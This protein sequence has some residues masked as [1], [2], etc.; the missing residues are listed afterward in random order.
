MIALGIA[1]LSLAIWLHLVLFHGRF[2]WASE[3]D[4]RRLPPPPAAWPAVVAVVPARDE[5]DVVA[6]SVGSLLAQDYPGAFRV[7]LVDDGSTD[8][9]A[10][11]ARAAAAEAGRADRLEV[12]RAAPLAA[13]WTGKLAAVAQGVARAR[14]GDDP[15][16]LMLTDADIGHAPDALRKLV[17]RAEAKGLA[18]ASIMVKLHCSTPAERFLIPAFVFFFQMLYP[19]PTANDPRRRLAAGA[20]GCMLANAQALERAGGIAAIR[21]ALI[22]DCTLAALLKREGPIW[23]GLTRTSWSLR[24]YETVAQVGRM[25]SRSAYAQLK[26]SPALLVGTVLGMLLVYVVPPL[27]AVLGHGWT[28]AMGAAAWLLMALS[29]Q[30]TLR[31]YRRSPLWGL[32]LPVIGAA[33][34]VFTVQ[35][36]LDHGRGRGGMWKGRAQAQARSQAA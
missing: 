21:G 35:S 4:D 1:G 16:Y 30:P 5:A 19:F 36:A 32:V 15:K 27:F 17:V 12:L 14:Q 13:G 28:R 25:V 33:Y 31:L 11:A 10:E 9:T 3:R 23:I 6:R 29:F 20:G 22:D 18:L 7:V 24:P 2:W 26:Y 34:C 8:G